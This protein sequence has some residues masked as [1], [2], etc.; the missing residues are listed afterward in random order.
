MSERLLRSLLDKIAQVLF[1]EP[2]D[3]SGHR[4]L[5]GGIIELLVARGKVGMS[6]G[7]VDRSANRSL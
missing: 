5:H 1:Q 2:D 6:E 3:M 4:Q 7:S